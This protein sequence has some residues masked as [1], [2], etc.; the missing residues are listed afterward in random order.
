MLGLALISK[1][2][3]IVINLCF[4]SVQCNNTPGGVLICLWI[5]VSHIIYLMTF[6]SCL[7]DLFSTYYNTA[8]CLRNTEIEFV[9]SVKS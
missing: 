6:I 2:F 1:W 7:Q 3:F 5:S 9:L 8:E 4:L